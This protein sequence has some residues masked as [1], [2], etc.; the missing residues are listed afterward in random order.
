MIVRQIICHS[1]WLRTL[2]HGDELVG[3]SGRAGSGTATRNFNMTSASTIEFAKYRTLPLP[4]R[5]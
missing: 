3:E 2:S 1:R 4:A 5:Y